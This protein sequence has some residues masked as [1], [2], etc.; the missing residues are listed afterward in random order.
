[1]KDI[2]YIVQDEIIAKM[3]GTIS[4][5]NATYNGTIWTIESCNV[6]W[7]RK[8]KTIQDNNAQIFTIVSVDYVANTM[9]LTGGNTL[10]GNLH[11][12]PPYFFIGTPIKTNTEW[13]QFSSNE[14]KKVPFIWM[15]E[16]TRERLL[17][18][19]N[20]N[21]RESDLFLVLLDNSNSGSWL[22]K[23]VHAQRLQA[24]Y[25]MV[26][27]IRNVI[28]SNKAFERIKTDISVKNFTRFG[29]ETAQGFD[30]NII[31]ADL[32]GIEMRFPLKIRRGTYLCKC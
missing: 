17:Q 1:M 30:A 6:K 12:E 9:E 24:L 29:T 31:D 7:A 11:I 26:S 27:E 25:N 3:N 23:D 16:P 8:G 10:I 4:V 15:V 21:D 22:T 2:L 28:N 20:P 18:D 14:M 5:R 19:D 32:T 13:L